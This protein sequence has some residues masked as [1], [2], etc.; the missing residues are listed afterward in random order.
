MPARPASPRAG[1]V[2]TT[3]LTRKRRRCNFTPKDDQRLRACRS[4]QELLA[5]ISSIAQETRF[6]RRTV[7]NHAKTLGLWNKFQA[8][9]LEEPAI[10]RLF[11]TS[12]TQEDALDAIA[13]RLRISKTA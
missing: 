4:R 3:T 5:V 2:A 11:S 13:T 8:P 6:P 12:A 7:V 9:R 1:P 10:V